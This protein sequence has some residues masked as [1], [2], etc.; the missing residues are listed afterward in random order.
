MAINMFR[1]EHKTVYHDIYLG[2]DIYAEVLCE[3]TQP[4][5][6]WI[7]LTTSLLIYLFIH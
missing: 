6:L 5:Y 4:I 7:Y 1:D 2:K 3:L